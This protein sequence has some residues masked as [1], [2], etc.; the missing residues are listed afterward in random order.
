MKRNPGNPQRRTE[1]QAQ[2][3]AERIDVYL[4]KAAILRMWEE[5]ASEDLQTREHDYL[6]GLRKRV[7][8]N[9]N[10]LANRSGPDSDIL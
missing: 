4:G 9:H 8:V 5:K 3:T 7:R 1:A 10:Y 6:L 2:K